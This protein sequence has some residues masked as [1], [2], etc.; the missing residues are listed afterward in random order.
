MTWQWVVF[1]VSLSIIW[2]IVCMIFIVTWKEIK[3]ARIKTDQVQVIEWP[4][5]ASS[6]ETIELRPK[7]FN[8]EMDDE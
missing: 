2:A 5:D 8:L 1:S 4:E 6:S 3:L 7:P